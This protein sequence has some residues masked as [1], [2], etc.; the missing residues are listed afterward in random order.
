MLRIGAQSFAFLR[1]PEADMSRLTVASILAKSFSA[2]PEN[3]ATIL[4]LLS[5]MIVEGN[6]ST[7]KALTVLSSVNVSSTSDPK[8]PC[9]EIKFWTTF[10]SSST[11]MSRTI[12]PWDLYFS[13]NRRIH[14]TWATQGGHHAAQKSRT[15]V[16]PRKLLS[17]TTFPS[18]FWSAKSDAAGAARDAARPEAKASNQIDRMNRIV[19]LLRL[20]ISHPLSGAVHNKDHPNSSN[21]F[22]SH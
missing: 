22:L 10:R 14:G 1:E 15:T 16:C 17:R 9:S 8:G 2:P 20:F 4:P 7:P 19:G 21:A 3:V 5:T 6:C 13:V 11:L 12:T 18:K